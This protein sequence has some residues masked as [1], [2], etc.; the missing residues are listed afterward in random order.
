MKE[1][2]TNERE[3]LFKPTL[4]NNYAS[5]KMENYVLCRYQDDFQTNQSTTRRCKANE[6]NMEKSAR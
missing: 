5:K 1:K 3:N 6:S 4:K 2:D